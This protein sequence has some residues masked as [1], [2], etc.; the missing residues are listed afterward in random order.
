MSCL[1]RPHL[2]ILS[3][4]IRTS[5]YAIGGINLHS[6]PMRP[7]RGSLLISVTRLLL[8]GSPPRRVPLRTQQPVW[9]LCCP[10]S[11][12]GTKPKPLPEHGPT[13]PLLYLFALTWASRVSSTMSSAGK[14]TLEKS[15]GRGTRRARQC[16]EISVCKERVLSGDSE[17][18]RV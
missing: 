6:V 3:P 15:M 14:P 5:A 9:N 7:S 8:L 10:P 12:V 4:D 18:R 1:A 2:L 13:L 11:A 16:D 17:V